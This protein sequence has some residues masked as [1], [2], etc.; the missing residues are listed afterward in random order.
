[1]KKSFFSLL[2]LLFLFL[3]SSPSQIFAASPAEGNPNCQCANA[4]SMAGGANGFK[5][6]PAAN[7]PN[8]GFC[9]PNFYCQNGTGGNS[10]TCQD[11]KTP[12]RIN[13]FC[14]SV[15]DTLDIADSENK[16][17]GTDAVANQE[18]KCVMRG[19][20]EDDSNLL[21][22]PPQPSPPPPPCTDPAAANGCASVAT[23]F[24]EWNTDAPGF[25]TSLFG[26][27]LSI[28]GGIAVFIIMLSGYKMI[29]SQGDPEKVAAAKETLTAAIVGL[30]FL[31]F[32]LVIL[33][34][35]GV[36]ILHLPGFGA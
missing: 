9:S 26:I 1:V 28:S 7:I 19:S 3:S 24:G 13:G 21:T 18:N 16:C 10:P 17:C 4:D 34:V 8:P 31:I 11:G 20:A 2:V 23:A 6:S 30:L 35:I 15:G 14:T 27:L 33:Q 5:C 12:N 25:V 22:N 36:D 32:A 29:M